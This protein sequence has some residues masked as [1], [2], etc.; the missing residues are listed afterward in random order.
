MDT[1]SNI[2]TSN[3]K[4]SKKIKS[5]VNENDPKVTKPKS[6]KKSDINEDEPKVT[7][8]KASKKSTSDVNEDEPKVTKTK[9]S[10]KSDVNEDEPKISTIHVNNVSQPQKLS[11][12]DDPEFIE[13]KQSWFELI[14]KIE[15]LNINIDELEVEKDIFLKKM[16]VILEKY[17]TKPENL[18]DQKSSSSQIFKSNLLKT[19]Y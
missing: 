10:K 19:S 14:K 7:K 1:N 11:A 6:S 8:P 17:Q 5:D 9:A 18:I 15:E 4:A 12:I 3:S 13:I 16:C 2:T